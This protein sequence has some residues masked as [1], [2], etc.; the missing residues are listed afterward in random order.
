MIEIN[1]KGHIFKIKNSPDEINLGEFQQ[2]ITAI[3][4]TSF[5][6]ESWLN[7]LEILSGDSGIKKTIGEDDFYKVITHIN[8]TQTDIKDSIEIDGVEYKANVINNKPNLSA[9]EFSEIEKLVKK[10]PEK[11]LSK[12]MSI[13]FNT[14]VE[15]MN[16][17][18]DKCLLFESKMTI[19]VALPY[20]IKVNTSLLD[21][22]KKIAEAVESK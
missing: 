9:W 1:S 17:F 21:N 18:K 15:D 22:I 19:D 16:V 2:V 12:A 14:D 5:F 11:W 20:V 10:Y 4:D 3:D 8:F 6:F 13:I 7:I